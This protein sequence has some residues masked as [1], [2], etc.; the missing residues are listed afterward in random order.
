MTDE[1]W[2]RLC[3]SNQMY[4]EQVLEVSVVVLDEE[5]GA[6][7]SS[8]NIYS[9]ALHGSQLHQRNTDYNESMATCCLHLSQVRWIV[10]GFLR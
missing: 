4:T 6:K 3:K 7:S 10:G 1:A 9:I 2:W 8:N 5:G